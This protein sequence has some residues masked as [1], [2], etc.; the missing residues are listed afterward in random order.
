VLLYKAFR[1]RDIL[2]KPSQTLGLED[3]SSSPGFICFPATDDFALYDLFCPAP[4]AVHATHPV[5]LVGS[6]EQLGYASIIF[7]I[8]SSTASVYLPWATSLLRILLKLPT[9]NIAEIVL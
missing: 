2:Y 1:T 9:C 4:D 3:F 6:F 5:Y 7:R 8:I